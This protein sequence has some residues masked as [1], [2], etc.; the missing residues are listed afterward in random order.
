MTDK[1]DIVLVYQNNPFDNGQG[2]GNIYVRNLFWQLKASDQVVV[3]YW[4]SFTKSRIDFTNLTNSKNYLIFWLRFL[5]KLFNKKFERNTVL[6]FHRL[7]FAMT[8]HFIIRLL[9]KKNVSV[10]TTVHGETFHNYKVNMPH[11]FFRTTFPI[12]RYLESCCFASLKGRVCFVSERNK[13]F[14]IRRHKKITSKI[15]DAPVFSSMINFPVVFE[16]K[17]QN[18]FCMLGRLS[19]VKDHDF[20]FRTIL[21]YREVLKASNFILR[22]FG[23]GELRQVLESFVVKNQLN[24]LIVLEG[25]I[26]NNSVPPMLTASKGLLL[27]SKNEAAPTVILEA[28]ACKCPVFSTDVGFANE[29]L[30]NTSLGLVLPREPSAFVDAILNVDEI[31]INSNEQARALDARSP[32]VIQRRY[33]DELYLTVLGNGPNTS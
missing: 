9:R 15:S 6:H 16:A 24:D 2:G 10:V 8:A 12:L 14:F 21:E 13:E 27:T 3:H 32:S 31:E 17:K 1:V 28:I 20:I 18:Y 29:V 30:A 33:T 4:G 19:E 26:E 23:D 11:L 25:E 5:F 7:Y 22:I